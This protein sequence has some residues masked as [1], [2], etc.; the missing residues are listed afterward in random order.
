M[1]RLTALFIIL[2]LLIPT[3]SFGVKISD[4]TALTTVASGDLLP[5]VDVSETVV[6]LQTKKVTWLSLMAAPGAIGGTTPGLAT[7]DNVTVGTAGAD[8]GDVTI[9]HGGVVTMFDEDNNFSVTLKV[10]DGT[11]HLRLLG[12]ID[13]SGDVIVGSDVSPDSSDGASIGRTDREWMDLY[14]A[15]GAIIYGQDDQGNTLT[16]SAT[17]WTANL[18]FTAKSLTLSQSTSTDAAKNISNTLVDTS[19]TG[20]TVYGQYN[21]VT[22]DVV[23]TGT[24]QNL[25]GSRTWVEKSGADTSVDVTTVYG[26]E[27][28]A[29]N[30]GSTDAGTKNTYALDAQAVGDT[31]GTSTT[32]GLYTYAAGADTNYGIFSATGAI[33]FRL[34]AAEDV[35]IN[36][37][38]TETTNTTG[39]LRIDVDTVTASVVGAKIELENKAT[40]GQGNTGLYVGMTSSAIVTATNQSLYG[41]EIYATKSGADTSANAVNI[42]GVNVQA[43]N[44]GSTDAGTRDTTGG[45]F[46]ATGDTAGTSIAYGLYATASGA[47]TNYAGY[48]DGNVHIVGAIASSTVT[49]TASADDTDVS[50]VNTLFINPGAAV[51]IGGFT[52]GVAGQVLYVQV[53]DADQTVTLE[54][55]EGVGGTQ[56][57][58]MHASGDEAAASEIAGWVLICDGTSWYDVSHAKHV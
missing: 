33:E 7:F 19:T 51:V 25:Y 8:Q 15:D 16:S 57:L 9:H 50:G 17:G 43:Q 54:D 39:V 11:T 56:Q 40:T 12:N 32:Y 49:I 41:A 21:M 10:T 48:F 53:V 45:Y 13:V 3:M 26:L 4:L 27:A 46:S 31:A 1:K 42:R 55:Q 34:A 20:I 44:T 52:G 30:T 6:N 5:I 23:V 2:A 58:Y 22:N 38:S 35:F 18:G 36:G 47:D 37:S 29:T 24:A 14:L 28:T